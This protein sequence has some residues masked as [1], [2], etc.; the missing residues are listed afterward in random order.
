MYLHA[1]TDCYAFKATKALAVSAGSPTAGAA[2][3]NSRTAAP[4]CVVVSVLSDAERVAAP[5]SDE[6]L[7]PRGERRVDSLLVCV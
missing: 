1:V 5:Q 6:R 2:V 3:A 4:V 7:T